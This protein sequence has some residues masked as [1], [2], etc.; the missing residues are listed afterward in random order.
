[1]SPGGDVAGP[2]QDWQGGGE[3]G[4]TQGQMHPVGRGM[5]TRTRSQRG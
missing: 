5:S 1:M 2:E 4:A 3:L